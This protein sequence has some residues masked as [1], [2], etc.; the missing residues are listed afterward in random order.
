MARGLWPCDECEA[1]S[2]GWRDARS[3]AGGG[4]GT[5][6]GDIEVEVVV[7]RRNLGCWRL[8]WRG[9]GSLPCCAPALTALDVCSACLR[10]PVRCGSLRRG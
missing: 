2:L 5:F 3:R 6:V 4:A 1:W 8:T 10:D 7:C 9:G